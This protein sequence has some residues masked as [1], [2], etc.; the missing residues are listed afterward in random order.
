MDGET[1]VRQRH[2]EALLA[3]L[4]A[5]LPAARLLID[6]LEC[7]LYSRDA[8]YV[9]GDPL[10]VAV[11]ASAEELQ[12]VV[13]A[14]HRH[15]VPFTARGA[16]TALT[17]SASPLARSLVVST[18]RMNAVESLDPTARVAWVQP[19]VINADLSAAAAP[20]GLMYAPD[21]SSQTS[22]TIGGN[23]A[24]NAGGAHTLLHGVTAAHVLAVDLVLPDGRTTRLGSVGAESW[25]PDLRALVVGSEGTT[26]IVARAAVR[27]T[28]VAPAHRTLL[29]TFDSPGEAGA[30]VSAVIGEGI[31]AA[32]LELM[33]QA[34]TRAVE[35]YLRAGLPVDAGA[36]LLVEVEGE[37][38]I[39][40]RAAADIAEI[41]ADRSSSPP[42]LAASEAERAVWWKARKSALGAMAQIRPNYYL[43][44]TVIPRTR[45][46]EVL[47]AIDDISARCGLPIVNVFHAGDGNLHPIIAYDR[48]VEGV[49]DV[50]LAAGEEIIKVSL[51][52][53]GALTG[54]HGIGVEKLH[55]MSLQFDGPSLA[56]QD[57]V[58]AAFDPGGLANPGKVLPSP[59]WC[60]TEAAHAG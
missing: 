6:P 36:V 11:V 29:L 31:Q 45:L 10:G 57:R 13:A 16:G 47:G 15:G 37:P 35:T 5:V 12:A 51:A 59:R 27:L 55:Y 19:G 26:G 9:V 40:D 53:G 28:P 22:C 21:P 58:R 2:E 56:L 46:A 3:D 41:A 25:A 20:F 54:E 8:S 38:E 1:C 18:A 44:D 17:G 49:F 24:T 32:A 60:G 48:R 34:V 43:H 42:R 50:V 30:T 7:R 39:V 52:A 14:C 33:D 4:R 23:I